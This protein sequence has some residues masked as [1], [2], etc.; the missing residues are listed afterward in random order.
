MFSD[1]FF[2]CHF[3][4]GA[5]PIF[6]CSSPFT[7]AASV[8]AHVLSKA[9]EDE[10]EKLKSIQVDKVVELEYDV[11]NLLAYDINDIDVNQLR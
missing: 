8:V 1:F 7:M 4:L 2:I 6:S 9:A 10:A 3:E 11:G 5:T